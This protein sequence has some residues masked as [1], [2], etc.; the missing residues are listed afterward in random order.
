MCGSGG[1][2]TGSAKV[3]I[4]DC[5]SQA[6]SSPQYY[7]GINV[8]RYDTLCARYPVFVLG[9]LEAIHGTVHH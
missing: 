5:S 1:A 8:C 3:A 2:I 4:E 6:M 9:A 7:V